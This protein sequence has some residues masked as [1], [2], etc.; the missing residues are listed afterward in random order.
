MRMAIMGGTFNPIHNGH[1]FLAEEVRTALDFEK[2]IFIPAFLPA[3]KS[4]AANVPTK[5]RLAMVKLALRGRRAFLLDDCEIKRG[6]ISY[7]IDTV[8]EI[9]SKYTVTGKPGLIIGDDLLDQ[10]HIWNKAEQLAEITTLIVA[11][12]TYTTKHRFAFPHIYLDNK[13]LPISASE[14]RQRIAS[15]KPIR[16]LLPDRVYEYIRA[17]KLYT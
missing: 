2:I 3:H 9:M 17:H 14:I 12:R 6:G 11:K 10:F 16:F 8:Q 5:H 1:L 15:C 13:I 4:I 7:M